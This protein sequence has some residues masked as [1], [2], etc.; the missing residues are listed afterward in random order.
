MASLLEEVEDEEDVDKIENV[1][2]MS[3]LEQ[4]RLCCSTRALFEDEDLDEAFKGI[5]PCA[6][7]FYDF[8]LPR[9]ITDQ[10]ATMQE[11]KR[12][13][14]IINESQSMAMVDVNDIVDKALE[15]VRACKVESSSDYYSTMSAL[16]ILSGRRTFELTCTL[17]WE[18]VDG[19][20]FQARVWGIAKKG[21]LDFA[22]GEQEVFA[23]PLL[24]SY[25][26]FDAALSAARAAH[27]VDPPSDSQGA[28][29]ASSSIG[30]TTKRLYGLTHT[31][32][33][34]VYAEVA[35]QRRGENG[36]RPTVSKEAWVKLALCHE[37]VF[38]DVTSVYKTINFV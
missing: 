38:A 10:Y 6:S 35:W 20:P 19:F 23:I 5:K 29:I 27:R 16:R 1:I 17:H 25:E 24:C 3:L 34:N 13:N 7:G 15:I 32:T 11:Q 14:R 28:K 22:A 4:N 37:L 2:G 9:H 8:V 26:E 36:F 18:A 21:V 12:T 31:S 33:R 30:R